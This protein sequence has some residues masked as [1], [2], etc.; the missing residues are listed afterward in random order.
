MDIRSAEGLKADAVDALVDARLFSRHS[1]HLK[2]ISGL[3]TFVEVLLALDGEPRGI[4][5]FQ[6]PVSTASRVKDRLKR[7]GLLEES[8]PAGP[9]TPRVRTLIKDSPLFPALM[10]LLGRGLVGQGKR[11]SMALST[12]GVASASGWGLTIDREESYG[13]PGA[14]V[15]QRPPICTRSEALQHVSSCGTSFSSPTP[16]LCHLDNN[17]PPVASGPFLTAAERDRALRFLGH[18][19]QQAALDGHFAVSLDLRF[20][21]TP[22]RNGTE[23]QRLAELTQAD[24]GF[25]RMLMSALGIEVGVGRVEL[26][27]VEGQKEVRRHAHIVGFVP[28]SQGKSD[29][30]R[31][32]GE[33]SQDLLNGYLGREVRWG[34]EKDGCD[35]LVQQATEPIG[36]ASYLLKQGTG[37]RK[38]AQDHQLGDDDWLLDSLSDLLGNR[39]QTVYVL[40]ACPQTPVR[41]HLAIDPRGGSSIHVDTVADQSKRGLKLRRGWGPWPW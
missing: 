41:P 6:L 1:G 37:D 15:V 17:T 3:E 16:P 21:V 2:P 28:A 22:Y 39:D 40:P 36:K 29:V 20:D 5:G 18:H 27:R 12:I 13:A 19:F 4:K 11:G 10:R 30:L 33:R 31:F 26:A 23:I 14:E 24:A 38:D 32:A 34:L 8:E 25:V 7:V 9:S 35:I